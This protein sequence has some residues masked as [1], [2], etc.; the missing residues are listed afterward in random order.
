MSELPKG[1]ALTT[2][3][4]V[5][6]PRG[7]KADPATLGEMPFL[8][9]DHIEAH[10]AKLLGSQPVSELKSAVVIFKNGD[11]LYGRLRPYLNKVHLA[12][13][14]GTASAEFIV[15]PT[16]EA[17]EQRFLQSLLRSTEYRAL[18]DQRSTGDRPRVKFENVS[19]YAFPLPP[20]P[21][22]RRIVTKLDTLSTRT[23]T[24]RTHLT[25]IAKLVEKHKAGFVSALFEGLSEQFGEIELGL[26]CDRITKGSSPKWQGFEYSDEGAI[27]VRSQ[28]VLWGR[29]NLADVTRLPI[30]FNEKQRNSVMEKDDVLLNIVGASIGRSAVVP[31]EL[32][33]A[34]CNQAVAVIRLREPSFE[35]ASYLSQWLISPAAQSQITENAVDVA[36]ANF[37]LGQAKKLSI[38]WATPEVRKATLIKIETAFAK[39]DR[40][41]AEAEKALKL[42]D[43]LDQRI[44][45]KA[46]A[47]ELVPQDPTDE[48]AT[49]LLARI[50][51]ARAAAPKPKRGRKKKAEA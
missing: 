23:T 43:R 49:E 8:G 37:S 35:D 30:E 47:G 28:N 41:A 32:V 13:F 19:D 6:A 24:A 45:A 22:Q 2:L 40:L 33:G 3:A 38:P 5:T 31:S 36:R 34:N 10:T 42:T 18:A 1:W 20:L 17:I 15:F 9:M 14:D 7:E 46:F 26:V 48:P 25:A 29:L 21:E 51:E 12:Q 4:D 44:L 11:I 39:I 16:S 50:R 27:F